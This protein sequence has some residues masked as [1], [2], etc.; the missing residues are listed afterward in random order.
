MQN[1]VTEIRQELER[2]TALRTTEVCNAFIFFRLKLVTGLPG[3][4][5]IG[6]AY[7]NVTVNFRIV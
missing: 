7:L 3:L 1:G 6:G 2:F 5:A 4:K